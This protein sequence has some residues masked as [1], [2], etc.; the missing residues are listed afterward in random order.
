MADEERPNYVHD[1]LREDDPTH[2]MVKAP[3]S[4]GA[5]RE[6]VGYSEKIVEDICDRVACG[7]SLNKI[8]ASE[9]MPH[10]RTVMR[11]LIDHEE[12]KRRYDVAKDMQ[13]DA[14]VDEVLEIA[15]DGSKDWKTVTT[16]GGNEEKVV[17]NEAVQR[18]R[19]RVDARK[20]LAGVLKPRKYGDKTQLELS[21]DP[22]KPVVVVDRI[23]IV[24]PTM[25]MPKE[26]PPV[27]EH[28]NS[29][30]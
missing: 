21:S 14:L 26:D 15:D 8:C 22:N 16:R 19:L 13:A 28:V 1:I 6:P 25:A 29:S 5:I 18:S 9:G 4:D 30:D 20:W 2:G 23:E 12:F 17:D 11:W 7:E 27:I 10:R 24:A 3:L